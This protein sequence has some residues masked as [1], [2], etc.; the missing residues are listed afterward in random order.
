MN[1]EDIIDNVY[2]LQQDDWSCQRPTFGEEGQLEVVGWSG[3]QGRGSKLYILKCCECSKDSELFGEGYFKSQ[4]GGLIRGMIPCGCSKS[5]RRTEKQWEIICKRVVSDRDLEFIGFEGEWKNSNT[6]VR[7]LCKKH[8][9][10]DTGTIT[11]TVNGGCGCPKCH[12]ENIWR[13]SIK[14]DDVMIASFFDSGCF[15]P[16][17]KFWRSERR[18]YRGH[19]TFWFMHC[20]DCGITGEAFSGH[21]QRGTR[22]CSCTIHRQQEAYINLILN[23]GV[24]LAVKFGIANSSSS[25]VQT[26]NRKSIYDIQLYLI[27]VF[28]NIT[29]CKKAERECKQELECGVVL[30]Q[31]MP[32]GYTETT[33]ISEIGKIEEIYARNGGVKLENV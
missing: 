7:I 13:T 20:P 23:D 4:K 17:T 29:S 19:K 30:R 25:R 32:D 5:Y 1:L 22:P 11:S 8:G 21:L 3:E 12:V 15:H 26:Q 18:G 6:K 2:G 33:H 31:E 28:P 14:P 24:P 9:P 27:Y 10:W 16:D